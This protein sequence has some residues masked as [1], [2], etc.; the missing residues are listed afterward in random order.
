MYVNNS[1]S[2]NDTA[3]N[4][5]S[6]FN[7]S[8]NLDPWRAKVP[9]TTEEKIFY[10]ILIIPLSLTILIGNI[11]L[12]VVI[13]KFP[14]CQKPS[15]IIRSTVA[16]LDLC[17]GL[18]ASCGMLFTILGPYSRGVSQWLCHTVSLC[19][20]S[21]LLT[22]MLLLSLF[23]VERYIYLKYPL[24]YMKWLTKK[25]VTVGVLILFLP[26]IV[27]CI[28]TEIMIGRKRNDSI[29]GCQLENIKSSQIM[30]LF[31]MPSIL[32]SS[33]SIIKLLILRRNL[34]NEVQQHESGRQS[35]SISEIGIS[36]KAV[37]KVIKMVLLLSG[38]LWLTFIPA[39]IARFT[40]NQ[41][42]S[43]DELESK[44]NIYAYTGMRIC[45][46]VLLFGSSALNPVIQFIVEEDLRIGFLRVIGIRRDFVWQREQKA[47]FIENIKKSKNEAKL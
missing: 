37:K 38:S 1:T 42:F 29:I 40:I 15:K 30:I 13:H 12:I 9:N 39:G 23:T 44:S 5:D 36:R 4:L 8:L 7:S 35:A 14:L 10:A 18:V 21:C 3:S 47:A 43:W 32:I 27:Y 33:G 17:I 11:S 31:I 19:V 16:G 34:L 25:R 6:S 41:F 22:N 2:L 28:M 46:I 20:E 45:T 24:K 26:G